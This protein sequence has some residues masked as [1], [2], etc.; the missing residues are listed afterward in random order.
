MKTFSVLISTI[1]VAITMERCKAE[2]LL[3]EV[4]DNVQRNDN[5]GGKVTSKFIY[6][7]LNVQTVLI[8]C[9]ELLMF[10]LI[11]YD[12]LCSSNLQFDMKHISYFVVHHKTNEK[13]TGKPNYFSLNI[14]TESIFCNELS[15]LVLV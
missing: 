4:D 2:Y 13:I 5:H 6:S 9:N 7:S 10:D 15:I 3:V 8:S 1:L 11:L 12:Q 14:H